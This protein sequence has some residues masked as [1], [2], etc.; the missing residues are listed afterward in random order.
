M[1]T[2][3]KFLAAPVLITSSNTTLFANP[4]STS[5]YVAGV[6][7]FN[8]HTS[9]VDVTIWNRIPPSGGNIGTPA[10]PSA[11]RIGR[12]ALAPKATLDFRLPQVNPYL[13]TNRA[14]IALAS[15]TNVVSATV[16]GAIDVTTPPQ[17]TYSVLEEPVLLGTGTGSSTTVIFSNPSSTNTF[18]TGIFIHNSHA[19]SVVV[20]L[21]HLV[22]PSSGSPG[23]PAQAQ[24]FLEFTIASNA[25]ISF[26]YPF[27]VCYED[28]AR[29]L[30]GRAT[31]TNVVSVYIAG[32]VYV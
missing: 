18:N 21:W 13:D 31:V 6:L 28:T 32:A 16:C 17:L 25:T 23:T 11:Y 19:S 14:L 10:T 29:S 24:Q 9:S 20:Q 8:S 27:Q 15:V 26:L 2:I 3:P 7:L 12:I 1:A 30:R 5:S 4:V 22:P